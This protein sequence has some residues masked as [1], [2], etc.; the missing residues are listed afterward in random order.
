MSTGS[1]SALER[2]L[3][4]RSVAV[5]GA[6]EREGS[7]GH[8]TMVEL[9]DKGRFEGA[10][11]PVNPRYEE[12]FGHRC[13]T[14][15][16]DVPE[17]VDLAV[18]SLANALLEETL[19]AC[20]DAG[21][22]SAV[23]FASG[24]EEPRQDVPPLTE[25]LAAIARD[26]GMAIC[27][28][29][30]MGFVNV[31][32][33]LRATGWEEPA[34]L[35]PGGITFVSHSGS[36]FAA[37]LHNDRNLRLNLAVSSGQEFVTT[38]ADYM[39]HAL[40]L[41]S[42][43]AIGLFIEAVRDP[44]AFMAAL[45]AANERDV[46][47]VV[48]KVGREAF[49]REMVTAHSGALA[50]E[51]GAFEAL[52]EAFGV[53]RVESLDEMA[54][55]LALFV[56]GRRAGPGAL[57][58]AHDSGGERAMMV[59]AA[60][61]AGVPLATI[62]EKTV[63]F[64]ETVLDEGLLPVNPLDFWGTGR[65]AGAVIEGSLRAL[66]KDPAVAAL[67][68]AVDL[69]TDDADDEGY[70]SCFLRVWPET[71][72]PMAM[73]SNFAGGID[74]SDVRRIYEA[75]APALEG[76]L[77]GLAAF[78]HLFERRDHQALPP[79]AGSSPV[80]NEVRERWRARLSDG[81][82]FDELEALALLAGYGVPVIE[83]ARADTLEDA[84]A[85]AERIGLPVAMKTAAPGVQHKSDVGGVRLGIDDASSLEDAYSDLERELGP[86]VTVAAMAPEGVEVALGVVRDPQFGPLVLVAAGGV[87]IEV[88]RDRRLAL[89][90]LDAA[91]ARRMLDRLAVRP[92]L[93][94][95]RGA[96]PVDLAALERSVVALS[97]LAHDLGDDLEALDAN[98]VICGPDGCVAVDALVIPRS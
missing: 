92:L 95:V 76:T 16:A 52:F 9:L 57:A 35:E 88:L 91:R 63:L 37:L 22:G 5:I 47:V 74:R 62:S 27:G 56:A 3:E 46:P 68:F 12:L 83:S 80:G 4:A 49:T 67:A 38:T 29:N 19:T 24:F 40:A 10:V 44:R 14:S 33:G 75:G 41:E 98:P 89:P 26:A 94:G 18:I 6:S 53:H 11:Y 65:D 66:V 84:I 70:F 85:A 7:V 20:A 77:T 82:P 58:T 64:L 90:P 15:I 79:V 60:A 50:G 32:R 81:R 93:D 17:P 78:R 51:D 34:H 87:L 13:F 1:R 69:V 73:L 59:D 72:K 2:M 43:K 39:T 54:D 45:E 28:G 96:A 23:I 31:E 61:Q 42:T 86:Q 55:T 30:C 8:E 97:W 71:D 25:R 48:L 36:A 21:V